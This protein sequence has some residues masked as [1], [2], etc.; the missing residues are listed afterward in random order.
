MATN[1]DKGQPVWPVVLRIFKIAGSD[2][3]W[4]AAALVLNL[5]QVAAIVLGNHW[6]RQ[7]FDA[8]TARLPERFWLFLWLAL[9]LSAANIPLTYLRVYSIGRFSETTLARLR[10]LVGERSARL[11]VAYMETRHSGDILSVLNADLGKL[12]NLLWSHLVEVP[13]QSMLLI[14]ALAY[15]FW[16][17][18]ILALVSTIVSPALFIGISRLTAPISRRSAEMQDEIG[19]INSVAKDGLSGAMVIKA[20]NLVE[21][22]DRRFHLA[23]QQALRKGLQVARLRAGIDSISIGLSM[24]PFIIAMGLGGY[25][26]IDRRMTFGALFAFINLLNFVVDPLARLPDIFAS[27]AEAAGAGR[28]VFDLFDQEPE[29]AGG[30]LTQPGPANGSAVALDSVTFGYNEDQP[31]L[32][33]ISLD[34][35]PGQAV[36]IVG[37]SGS[38]KSTLLKLIL[39]YYPLADGRLRLFGHD[40][41]DWQRTAL[42]QQMAFVAQD[43]YL[44]PVSIGENIRL[45]HLSATQQEVETAARLA[46]IHDF[47][48][49][50]PQGYD[51][52]AGEWGGRLS[53]GQKQRIALARAI[54]KDAPILLL[55]EPT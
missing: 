53:G 7:T 29:P 46:N 8:A 37:P 54:L 41:S 43:T 3:G 15:I 47:I 12:R 22:L 5:V 11:P 27:I 6:V 34:I 36:A 21:I 45:G 16:V 42:R 2:R 31:V 48:A 1:R 14:A 23:N 49:S 20:F 35:P 32:K 17:N 44:F 24:T 18:W 39:G 55:D 38:G 26:V 19:Q 52:G 30:A 10:R 13:H 28:R 51:S 33:D 4:F 25:F 50:L 9:A 40:L